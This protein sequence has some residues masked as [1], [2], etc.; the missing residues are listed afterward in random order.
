MF[1]HHNVYRLDMIY[2]NVGITAHIFRQYL[3]EDI[4]SVV[5]F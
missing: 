4:Y 5:L 2:L 1:S 3:L